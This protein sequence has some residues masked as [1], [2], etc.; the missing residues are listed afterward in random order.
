M[1]ELGLTVDIHN[2]HTIK[3][4]DAAS[5]VIKTIRQ[6][7]GKIIW[8]P[9]LVGDTVSVSVETPTGKRHKLYKLP[10][11]IIFRTNPA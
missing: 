9:I 11:L 2:D 3:T 8:G 7:G 10:G 6:V 5:G 1:N 4:L